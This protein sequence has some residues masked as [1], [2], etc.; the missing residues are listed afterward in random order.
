MKSFKNIIFQIAFL[1]LFFITGCM[2][3]GPVKIPLENID[4]GQRSYGSHIVQDILYS[5][6]SDEGPDYL[7]DKKYITPKIYQGIRNSYAFNESYLLIQSLLG[8]IKSYRL[9]G[10][11]QTHVVRSLRYKL[12]VE[13]EG[14]KFVELKIDL[15]LN[16]DLA[17]YYLYVTTEDGQIKHENLLPRIVLR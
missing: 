9:F 13:N 17:G 7:L 1:I 14:F 16:D 2:N 12:T 11:E 10:A 4:E 6:K 3:D 8:D 5:F 15:N